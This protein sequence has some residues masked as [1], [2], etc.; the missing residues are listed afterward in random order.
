MRQDKDAVEKRQHFFYCFG[1][2]MGTVAKVKLMA[3]NEASCEEIQA[4]YA[5]SKTAHANLKACFFELIKLQQPDQSVIDKVKKAH[6]LQRV[7]VDIS[8]KSFA[9]EQAIK[10]K[11]EITDK[12]IKIKKTSVID[13]N[14]EQCKLLQRINVKNVETR[15]DLKFQSIEQMT[16]NEE[17][18][19]HAPKENDIG[20]VC[21]GLMKK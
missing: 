16:S 7:I 10:L 9:K 17:T 12:E 5:E 21:P 2:L 4:V 19:L 6:D 15:L 20:L 18:E 3:R 8:L 11:A 14:E 13:A 1:V